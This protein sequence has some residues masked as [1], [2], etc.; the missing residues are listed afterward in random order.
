MAARQK[1]KQG[2]F[3]G[4][5][6]LILLFVAAGYYLNSITLPVQ[7][8]EDQTITVPK[9]ASTDQ[10]AQIL[11][12][13][14]L[15]REAV[16]FKLYAKLKGVDGRFKAGTYYFAGKVSLADITAELLKGKTEE[17]KFTIPEGLTQEEIADLL[18]AKGLVDKE[19]FLTAANDGDYPYDYL[20]PA[21]QSNRL[22]GFLFPDTYQVPKG[23]GED[24][25]V[26]MMLNRFDQIFTGQWREQATKLGMSIPQ[27]V[28]MASLVER[29]AKVAVDR[30]LVS[31][32]FHNRLAIDMRLESCATIQYALGEVKA[33]LLYEDLEI[34]SPY[35]TYRHLGLPPG[36]IAAPGAAALEAA[37]Y[38]ADTDYL[39][40]VAKKDGSHFFSKTLAE[41][42]AAKAKY[43]K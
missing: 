9:S 1:K 8:N 29:E 43:L 24:L 42:N 25:I 14:K 36:P 17:V 13:K 7:L 27:V 30:P 10:I 4:P 22:E 20:P 3:L 19:K 28:T 38:P 34:E 33:V 39:F 16:V 2:S 11:A 15:V 31:S 37:L 26:A 41:H 23:Y 5:I 32:V 6:I 21:G 35:N 12:E 18:T 40:F